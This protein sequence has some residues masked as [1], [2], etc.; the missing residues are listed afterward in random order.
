M[1]AEEIKALLEAQLPE[2]E[3]SVEVDGSHVNVLAVGDLFEG[4]TPV[5]KQQLVYAG[6]TDQ[7]ADGTLH[8]INMKLYTKSQWQKLQQA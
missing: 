5:K 1:Q 8:A 7:I 2:C 3:V 6:L 4:L